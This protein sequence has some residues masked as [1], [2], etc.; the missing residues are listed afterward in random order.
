MNKV[1]ALTL[2]SIMSVIL[3]PFL[4][5]AVSKDKSTSLRCEQSTVQIFDSD[6]TLIP[7]IIL[8]KVNVEGS[9]PKTTSCKIKQAAERHEGDAVLNYTIRDQASMSGWSGSTMHS[10]SGIVVRWAKDGEKGVKTISPDSPLP[11]LE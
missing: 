11:V 6:K 3:Y 2:L 1:N 7:Y 10:G 8:G 4:C 9:T 5:S